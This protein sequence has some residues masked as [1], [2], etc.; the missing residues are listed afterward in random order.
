MD[1]R[2]LGRGFGRGGRLVAG[3]LA[4]LLFVGG[5]VVSPAALASGGGPPACDPSTGTASGTYSF[6]DCLPTGTAVTKQY[7]D[8]VRGLEFGTPIDVGFAFPK[9]GTKG[10]SRCVGMSGPVKL[11]SAPDGYR[12]HSPTSVLAAGPIGCAA[13]EQSVDAILLRCPT[14]CLSVSGFLGT[15]SN[16]GQMSFS[17]R[18]FDAAGTAISTSTVDQEFASTGGAQVPFSVTGGGLQWVL[19]KVVGSSPL[20]VDDLTYANDPAAQPSFAVTADTYIPLV[21]VSPSMPQSQSLH[22]TRANGSSGTVTFVATGLPA[23]VTA[24]FNPPSYAGASVGPTL[25]T[26][27]A[28]AGAIPGRDVDVTLAGDGAGVPAVGTGAGVVQ[29]LQVAVTVSF[30]LGLI[31]PSTAACT[32]QSRNL[33]MQVQPGFVGAVGVVAAFIDDATATPITAPGWAVTV[34]PATVSFN[35]SG[36]TADVALS[37]STPS[38]LPT[39]GVTLDVAAT[40]VGQPADTNS[41]R[42]SMADLKPSVESATRNL[43]PPLGT[44]QQAST[45]TVVAAGFCAGSMVQ[46]GNDEAKAPLGA[47]V[48]AGGVISSTGPDFSKFTVT[49]PTYATSGP[50]F[51][52]PAD[53][54]IPV[55]AGPATVRTYRNTDAFNFHNF[56]IN[57][58]TYDDMVRAFGHDQM[59]DTINLC[60]PADCSFDFRDPVAMMWTAI[61]RAFTVGATGSGHCYGISVTD[62]RLHNGALA[63]KSLP[64][65]ADTIYGL[66]QSPELTQLLLAAHLQ[67][68]SVEMF[69][70]ELKQS[71]QNVLG[72]SLL[73]LRLADA[74]KHGPAVIAVRDG[75]D[76]G[77]VVLAYGIE[78]LGGGHWLIDVY[79]S[80]REYTPEEDTD[81]TG[82]AHALRHDGS[83]ISIDDSGWAFDID[84]GKHWGGSWANLNSGIMVLPYSFVQTPMH[85]PSLSNLS[86]LA[87][88][89]FT[90]G[91][92]GAVTG[93]TASPVSLDGLPAGAVP[94][95]LGSRGAGG[96]VSVPGT[97]ALRLKA[98]A[99]APYQVGVFGPAGA[100]TVATTAETGSTDTVAPLAGGVSF[101]AGAASAL[102]PAGA[103]PVLTSAGADRAV[104][105]TSVGLTS[106]QRVSV[107]LAGTAGSGATVS[108]AV[109]GGQVVASAGSGGSVL[110]TV[111]T[112]PVTNVRSARAQTATLA[113]D[114]RAGETV[115]APVLAVA[116]G[117]P[118]VA[119]ITGPDGSRTLAVRGRVLRAAVLGTPVVRTTTKAGKATSVATFPVRSVLAGATGTAVVQVT[120]KGRVVATRTV[121][122]ARLRAPS[123]VVALTWTPRRGASYLVTASLSAATTASGAGLVGAA[124]RPVAFRIR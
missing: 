12:M 111:T 44:A 56:S 57:D 32:P 65:N 28:G 39:S 97:G 59:Y 105:L 106:A 43:V 27:T 14:V 77:H 82:A 1:S 47:G 78:D 18:G 95:T 87:D 21:V 54:G 20:W 9:D 33:R 36:T 26:Y 24:S 122:L 2:D 37:W 72:S 40:V 49:T 81:T 113:L 25:V 117:A 109:A 104:T 92:T 120:L 121:N 10:D 7:S 100:S 16:I 74:L 88:S 91:S 103:A 58:L 62:L 22:L 11:V 115:T 108:L 50:V 116:T 85:I 73:R 101:T 119:R 34:T 41:I 31:R 67:Q 29:K 46:V 8:G 17:V 45:F 3:A 114:L 61:V 23:G 124:V 86:T 79:D 94:L 51:V 71:A 6:E 30:P 64:R 89:I 4:A 80:N 5:L 112:V 70:E 76:E 102:T 53:N 90:F 35:G 42:A 52:I 48:P 110:L 38:A 99:N 93:S 84:S 83:R 63:V 98:T 68:F 107:T 69:G 66:T 123:V 96:V 75:L 19:I 60:W 55:A 118:L 15:G 13:G